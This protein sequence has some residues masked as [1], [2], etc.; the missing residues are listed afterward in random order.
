[1]ASHFSL[2]FLSFF[3]FVSLVS[4]SISQSP[5]PSPNI[6]IEIQ[7]AC[8]ASRDPP[9]CE[10]SILTDPS[11]L[12]PVQ[13]ILSAL[14]VSSQNLTNAQLMVKNLLDTSAGNVNLT[15][16]AKNCLLGFNYS[17]YRYNL[18]AAAF[19]R[20]E[21]KDARAWMSAALGYQIGCSSNLLKVNETIQVAKTLEVMNTSINFTTN[22]L[23]MTVSYDIHGNDT[24]LWGPP[25][26]ERD[27]FWEPGSGSGF[28]FKGGVPSGLNPN[29]TV[30]KEGGCDYK[31]VQEAVNA[32]PDN[33][34]PGKFVIW[35]KAGLYDEIVRVPLGKR[36]VVFLGDGMGK[37]VITGSLSVGLM[38]GMT[39]YESATVG[40]SGDGFMAS[41]L[42]IQ[43]TAGIGA[44]Q[45]VAFRSDSDLSIIQN[46][47]FLG[48]QDTLYTQ[49]L[50]Q[51]YK[52]CRIQ[53]NV[54]F[55]FG[56]AAAIFQDCNILVAP[57][58]LNP[59]KGEKNAVTAHGRL[60]PGQ[61]TG[62]VF[63][64]CSI[65]GTEEYMTLYHSNPK[66]HKTFLG[67]PWKEYSRTVF[68]NCNLEVLINSEG[69]M[70]WNGE[71]ALATLYYGEFNN[72]GAGA[73]ITGRV[74]WSSQIP[75]EHVNSYSVENFIQ[76]DKW[77]PPSSC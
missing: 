53:G 36:N 17:A 66:V 69:W 50:R 42:T 51:Y 40:V 21:I 10:A 43:N 62:Y 15:V 4:S 13:I 8:K 14:A 56:N 29:V 9:T 48:N 41:G 54:D 18:T 58:L 32:T 39:T 46:C 7:G 25:K 31:M 65:N 63:Q 16:A 60:D 35:I 12:T 70:P 23:W 22:A 20:G 75:A 34:G 33:L 30:C 47:E 3:L 55:I 37:T 61:S 71:F 6:P 57:R 77:I 67:R 49:S 27:G 73:N 59:E 72:S 64:N 5:S 11:N 28:G 1:M 52:S 26:T 19:P 45:A 44:G 2:P 74:T 76:G 68:I 38:P 24:G